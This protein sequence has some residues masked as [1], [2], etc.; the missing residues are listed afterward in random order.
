MKNILTYCLTLLAM[1]ILLCACPKKHIKEPIVGANLSGHKNISGYN[2]MTP[3]LNQN[4]EVYF[5]NTTNTYH[6]VILP[7]L[8]NTSGWQ[9][10][11]ITLGNNGYRISPTEFPTQALDVNKMNG[12]ALNSPTL[13]TYESTNSINYQFVFEPSGT[14]NVYYIKNTE[15]KYFTMDF[16]A[17]TMNF[18]ATKPIESASVVSQFTIK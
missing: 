15:G 3:E 13:S 18:I 17:Q 1:N 16:I 7:G 5:E 12:A 10:W 9:D 14:A 4:L 6:A 11:D 8:G 2:T